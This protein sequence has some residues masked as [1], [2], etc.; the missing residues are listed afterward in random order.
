M[1][2]TMTA[3]PTPTAAATGTMTR[4]PTP[5]ATATATSTQT[6]TAT[7]TAGLG[8]TDKNSA[9]APGVIINGDTVTVY[10]PE[11]SDDNST[12]GTMQVVVE[13]ASNPLPTPTLI[14]TDRVNSCTPTQSGEVVCS[15]QAGTV[16]LVP[17]GGGSPNI[18]QLSNSTIPSI[19]YANGV[20]LACGAMVDESLNLGIISSGLGFIPVDLI[21][22]TVGTPINVAIAPDLNQVPGMDFGYDKA[23]HL[24]L[25]ANYQILNTSTFTS[26]TPR[27][28]IINIS[29]PANPLIYRFTEAMTFFVGN[30]RMCG[31]GDNTDSDLWPDTT[32]LDTVTKVAYVSFHTKPTCFDAPPNDIAMFDMSQATFDNVNNVWDTPSKTIQSIT[33]TGLNGIDPISVESTNHLAL[34]SAGDNNF[35]VL[36]LPVK[37]GPGVTLAI[38]DWA[39][40]LMPNDPDGVA[41]AGWH[42][43][44]GLTTYVSPN[45]G[46]VMGV[47]MNNPMTSGNFSGSTYLALID[48]N[49]L[50][51]ATRDPINAH[52]VDSTVNLQGS[53]LLTFVKIK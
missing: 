5:T 28:Q 29:N 1:T 39:N 17:S 36:A 44:N 11:G 38:S 31:P 33:G 25:S 32:A 18:L 16:D 14:A 49:G 43:P 48:M 3:T 23:N 13:S 26:S 24:I 27:F 37:S 40:A 20:C 7:P 41:W 42:E 21:H 9:N 22:S 30:G 53:G 12:T 10:V 15:G 19:N 52:K 2:G 6:P 34:V 50:L 51:K 8:I 45:T 47:L 4:T 46:K 35:G